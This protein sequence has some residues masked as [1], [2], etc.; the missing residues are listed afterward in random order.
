MT[1][2]NNNHTH[3]PTTCDT[4]AQFVSAMAHFI[5]GLEAKA[6]RQEPVEYAPD[7]VT[8]QADREHASL[9]A[10]EAEGPWAHE[11]SCPAVLDWDELL[12]EN[13]V[14]ADSEP[15]EAPVPTPKV[16]DISPM[17]DAAEEFNAAE[18]ELANTYTSDPDDQG[19]ADAL[20]NA[21]TDEYDPAPSADELAEL[22]AKGL[23]PEFVS[24]I[25]A[26]I[27]S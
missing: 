2:Q 13:A 17:F 16:R 21:I 23:D 8:V 12:P 25:G 18:W 14:W 1:T 6:T 24:I 26:A 4:P 9:M 22:R 5:S 11:A 7:A 3:T 20:L 27:S 10:L 19:L 15:V